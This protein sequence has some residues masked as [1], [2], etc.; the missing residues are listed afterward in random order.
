MTKQAKLLLT[1]SGIAF[2][3]LLY[4]FFSS[5][6]ITIKQTNYKQATRQAPAAEALIDLVKLEVDYKANIKKALF[7]YDQILTEAGL[8]SEDS[9]LFNETSF[10]AGDHEAAAI[11]LSELKI[12]L[13]DLKVPE[14]FRDLHV[15]LVM[16][17]SYLKEALENQ[18]DSAR[19]EGLAMLRVARSEYSWLSE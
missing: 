16:S 19:A 7:D 8:S 5:T 1:L 9:L 10:V 2:L 15:D 13:M 14:E 12:S 3:L 17:L 18:D 4:L 6:P 11:N